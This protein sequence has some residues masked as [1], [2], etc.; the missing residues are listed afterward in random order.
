MH[1]PVQLMGPEAL[2]FRVRLSV[3][4]CRQRHALTGWPLNSPVS[5]CRVSLL[6]TFVTDEL[7]LKPLQLHC[8]LALLML[9]LISC[10]STG[11]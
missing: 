10:I 11:S 2:R 3:R 6:S 5:E 4:A 1:P 9:M 7:F 8:L